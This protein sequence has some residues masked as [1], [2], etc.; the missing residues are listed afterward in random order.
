MTTVDKLIEDAGELKPNNPALYDLVCCGEL[1]QHVKKQRDFIHKCISLVKPN[2]YF[3][4]SQIAATPSEEKN[5]MKFIEIEKYM[6]QKKC[7]PIALIGV[8]ITD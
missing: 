1:T 6:E 4:F 5:L 2:G 8:Q 3:F 7:L